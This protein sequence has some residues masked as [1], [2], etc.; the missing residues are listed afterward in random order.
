MEPFGI[1]PADSF[2]IVEHAAL[3]EHG[4]MVYN[5]SERK[6]YVKNLRWFVVATEGYKKA[7]EKFNAD[8]KVIKA[9]AEYAISKL[10]KQIENNFF[11]HLLMEKNIIIVDSK[12]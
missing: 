1:C 5:P 12:N 6:V 2:E 9:A 3:S 7:F 11:M 4:Q 8:D 10:H